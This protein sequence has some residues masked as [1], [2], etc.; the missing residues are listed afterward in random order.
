MQIFDKRNHN[1]MYDIIVVGAGLSGLVAVYYVLKKTQTLKILIVEK[2]TKCG[3]QITDRIA[4]E[5]SRW[6]SLDQKQ[7]IALCKELK[8]TYVHY[9]AIQNCSRHIWEFEKA[10]FALLAQWELQRFVNYF[11]LMT[12]LSKTER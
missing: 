7:L 1:T 9:P 5:D 6:F 8:V 3:G 12:K 10:R 11:D 4:S 2:E